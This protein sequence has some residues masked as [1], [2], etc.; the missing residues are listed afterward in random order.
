MKKLRNF[1]KKLFESNKTYICE[2]CGWETSHIPTTDK[3]KKYC[4]NCK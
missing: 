4:G 1:I 2:K 3:L